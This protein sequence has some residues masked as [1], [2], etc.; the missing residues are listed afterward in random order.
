MATYTF[1]VNGKEIEVDVNPISLL[2]TV[3]DDVLGKARVENNDRWELRNSDGILVDD[4][5]REFRDYNFKKNENI[6]LT[7]K[8][9]AHG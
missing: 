4:L 7:Y 1:V 2:K 6:Y 8:V 5:I 3:R 9:G